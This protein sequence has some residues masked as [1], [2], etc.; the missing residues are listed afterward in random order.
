MTAELV[1]GQNHLLPQTRVEI[2]ISAG[3][4]VTPGATL[5]DRKSVV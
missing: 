1:R 5:G 3:S 2:R 4:P